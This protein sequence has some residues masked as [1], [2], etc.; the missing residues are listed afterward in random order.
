MG[1]GGFA[2]PGQAPLVR[3]E[4]VAKRFGPVTVLDDVTLDLYPGEVLVL[5]G[6]NGA[7]KSTLIKMLAGVHEPDSGR[8]LV[9][10]SPVTLG[11]IHAAEAL[12]IATIHQELSVVPQMSVAENVLLGHTPSKGG[13]VDRKALRAQARAALALVGFDDVDVDAPIGH[14]GVVRQQLVM[15]AKA[16]SRQSRLVILDEPTAALTG[17]ETEIL[18]GLM[19]D[20]RRRGVA[21][22]FISHHLEEVARIGDRVA[23]LR[24]G[25]L[26]DTVAAETPQDELI[27]LMVGRSIDNH[28]PR[29][30]DYDGADDVLLDVRS[31]NR[32]GTLHDISLTVRA[33]E[34][35]GVAGL[36]GSGRSELIR[37]IAGAD[38]YDSGEVVVEGHPVLS[39]RIAAAIDAGIGHVPEDRKSQGLVLPASVAENIG[40]ATMAATSHAG[41]VDRR[42]QRSRAGAVAERLRVRMRDLDQAVRDLSGG[43]QQ[44]VVFARWALAGSRVLLLDEPTRGVD[45]GARVEIYEFINEVTAAGGAVLMVSSDLPEVLGMSDRVLVMN[46]GRI[47]GER[48]A[49]TAT[50]DDI[51]TLAASALGDELTPGSGRGGT[52]VTSLEG[53]LAPVATPRPT[54][55]LAP[56][57]APH[58][59]K[60]LR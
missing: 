3:L 33:G 36:V 39:G 58:L 29:R 55:D 27:R 53:S 54:P 34:V 15:I 24:D 21:M 18:F 35:V 19:E 25:R 60:D 1:M 6:E 20:L 23:V 37:A 38:H 26:I 47:A 11:S 30:R 5:L 4:R 13:L 57:P 16:L 51:M 12:G 46:N 17:A 45:V 56:D 10:G 14:L 48:D 43:N 32:R 22:V 44:K 28:Y 40:Y 50:Q 2:A 7:G 8:I 52:T 41:L 59:D 9:D 49:A 42:G 31:L